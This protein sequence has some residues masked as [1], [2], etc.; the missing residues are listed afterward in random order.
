MSPKVKTLFR[1]YWG[2][3]SA[4]VMLL[5]SIIV[6]GV[7]MRAKLA[8]A[9]EEIRVHVSDVSV[10]VSDELKEDVAILK[11]NTSDLR[12]QAA[13]MDQRQRAILE[14]LAEIKTLVKERRD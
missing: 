10:H 3:L 1:D 7:E 14:S 6:G 8:S 2:P 13:Q 12:Y 5:M 11:T 9:S 4:L